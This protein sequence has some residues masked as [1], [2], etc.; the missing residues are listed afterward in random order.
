MSF[1]KFAIAELVDQTTILYW[2]NFQLY[3]LENEVENLFKTNCSFYAGAALVQ[4][5]VL[6]E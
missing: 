5:F 2:I 4:R 1:S 6:T 3:A